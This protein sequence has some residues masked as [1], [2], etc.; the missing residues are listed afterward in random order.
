MLAVR[1]AVGCV[2]KRS[3]RASRAHG[4]RLRGR[5]HAGLRPFSDHVEKP[6]PCA[7]VIGDYLSRRLRP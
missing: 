5:H 7:Q 1:G 6:E 3:R 2:L 4:G